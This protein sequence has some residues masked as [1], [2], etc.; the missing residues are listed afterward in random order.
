MCKKTLIFDRD[1]ISHAAL[2]K[3]LGD[4]M[5]KMIV[6]P[7]VVVGIASFRKALKQPWDIIIVD[8]CQFYFRKST[9]RFLTIFVSEV[10]RTQ[11]TLLSF[12]GVVG[13]V[14]QKE[15]L[16]GLK[17]FPLE[18]G[19]SSVQINELFGGTS[20][21][22]AQAKIETI[23]NIV[24]DTYNVPYEKLSEKNR[25][26]KILKARQVSIYLSKLFTKQSL[27][28]IGEEFGGRH[29]STMIHSCQTVKD[30]MDTDEAFHDEIR[31]FVLTIKQLR[32][33]S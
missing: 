14:E 29:Y 6:K 10:R 33:A 5:G 3:H 27:K 22:G 2:I 9:K 18:K 16:L 28:S 12:L 20:S 32:I 24:C 11:T 26:G 19:Y 17:I 13:T 21:G 1:T 25:K 8:F 7:K 4:A 15:Y 23:R 31:N 30:L